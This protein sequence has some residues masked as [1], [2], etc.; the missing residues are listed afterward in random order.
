MVLASG[1]LDSAAL[2]GWALARYATVQ[3]LYCRFGLKWERAER[4]W[5]NQFLRAVKIRGLCPIAEMDLRNA[6]LYDGHWST[7]GQRV[8]GWNSADEA[9]Y[10]PGRNALLLVQAGVYAARNGL[11]DILIG[12]LKGNPFSDATPLFFKS[13]EKSLRL[14]LG[15]PLRIRAPFRKMTKK[16]AL[17]SFQFLP[18]SLA[19]SCLN[20]SGLRPCN[21]CNKCAERQNFESI[22]GRPTP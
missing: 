20:P 6:G 19:F 7:S 12:T 18:L 1:G 15:K 5:L 2:L 22:R 14:G 8:P 16:E 21:A 17:S 10:L 13:M 9:V 11:A 3:P 4:Y